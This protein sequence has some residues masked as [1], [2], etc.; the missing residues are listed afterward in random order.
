[1]VGVIAA[2]VA[3]QRAELLEGR[4]VESVGAGFKAR[5]G[6]G[7]QLIN[8]SAL[9]GDADNRHVEFAVDNH[10]LK[11]GEDLLER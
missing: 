6:A 7:A 4:L 1:M 10:P 11:C 2:G 3:H 9:A 8:M 5:L